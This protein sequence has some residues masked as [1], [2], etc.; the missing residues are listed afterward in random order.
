MFLV[1]KVIDRAELLISEVNFCCR[2]K[3]TG[4]K[5]AGRLKIVKIMQV[6]SLYWPEH[7]SDPIISRILIGNID[8]KFL[9]EKKCNLNFFGKTTKAYVIQHQSQTYCKCIICYIRKNLIELTRKNP[10]TVSHIAYSLS[11]LLWYG[12]RP[13]NIFVFLKACWSF[14]NCISWYNNT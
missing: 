10:Q 8:F 13:E 5:A 11:L 14:T 7:F 3:F 9:C 2:I 12:F 6:N 4:V 1:K